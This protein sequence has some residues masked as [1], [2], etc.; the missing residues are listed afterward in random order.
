MCAQKVRSSLQKVDG[1]SD[2][3]LVMQPATAHFTFDPAKESMQDL[4]RAVRAAGSEYDA[5]LMLQS[6]F[7]DDKLSAALQKVDGVRNP[8]M[9]D[10]KGIRLLTFL[11][12]KQTF[13]GDIVKAAT[14]I[15]AT[16]QTPTFEKE[17]PGN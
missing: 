3:T 10:K 6:S 2:L 13:Y 9:Q 1:L 7:D 15:G 12:D 5:R 16:L 14:S 17:K 11:M 8:G 4:V